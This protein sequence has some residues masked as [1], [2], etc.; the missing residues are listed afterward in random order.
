MSKQLKYSKQSK[1]R[2]TQDMNGATFTEHGL[3]LILNG[4]NSLD[5]LNKKIISCTKT[6]Q[7]N[8]WPSGLV[9]A[10]KQCKHS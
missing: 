8:N 4:D 10:S 1:A 9:L 7:A 5:V 2:H 3:V 6:V